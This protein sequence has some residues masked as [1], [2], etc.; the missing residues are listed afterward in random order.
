MTSSPGSWTGSSL[1]AG[2]ND[3]VA[4]IIIAQLLFLDADNRRGHL[5]LPELPFGIVWS[6]TIYDTIQHLRAPVNMICMGMC[7]S[8]GAFL[9]AA[10]ARASGGAAA[11]P[12]HDP[13]AVGG[14]RGPPRTSI[15]ARRSSISVQDERAAES[16]YRPVGRDH[17]ADV[18]RTGSV[19][20]PGPMG[21]STTSWCPNRALRAATPL[22]WARQCSLEMS[23]DPMSIDKQLRC[24]FCGKS[25]DSVGNSSPAV[26]L[27][28]NASPSATRF[29]RDENG[30]SL[31]TASGPDPVGDQDVS[32]ST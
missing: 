10:G 3:D 18:D 31:K 29:C 6:G 1:G 15:Q 20:R 7:A 28:M 11:F 24:S 21:S 5:S 27:P 17:R 4:N 23:S 12:D 26:A 16:A 13:P 25:G 8:M 32:T 14:P 9:L 22:I 30:K 2:I 19:P